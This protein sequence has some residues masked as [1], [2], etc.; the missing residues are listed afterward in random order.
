MADYGVRPPGYRLP[1]TAHVGAIRLQVSNLAQSLD[2]YHDV[3]GL[4]PLHRSDGRTILGALDSETPLVELHERRGARP[5][6]PHGRFGLYHFALLLPERSDLARFAGHLAGVDARV[7]S[8]DH[9]VSEALYLWDPDGLGIE[10]YADRPRAEWRTRGNELLMSTEPLD[11]RRLVRSVPAS[12][13]KGAPR[14]TVVG[15]VHLHVGNLPRAEAFYHAGL[16][17]DKVVWSYPGALFMS[18][19]GY[20]HHLAVN[21]W[22]EG[23]RVATDD[24]A[25]LLEWELVVPDA[26]DV[27]AAAESLGRAGYATSGVDTD[28]VA[29]DEWGTALR[30]TTRSGGS[31]V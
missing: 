20:H 23:G 12:G 21:T 28:R 7:A 19:G 8:A 22:L 24:D 1:E 18:A 2:Y 31:P 29:R 13:W 4:Q 30:L 14:G 26:A 17:F 15:H 6:P 27:G 16:G 9:L 11:V 25:R 5:V 3:I 10:V